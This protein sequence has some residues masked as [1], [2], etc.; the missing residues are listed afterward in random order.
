MNRSNAQ[1]PSRPDPVVM[2]IVSAI[3]AWVYASHAHYIDTPLFWLPMFALICAL[4]APVKFAQAALRWLIKRTRIAIAEVP[5]TKH[6]SARWARRK[7][8]GKLLKSKNAPF[9]GML[10]GKPLFL[11]YEA[12]AL[13]VA[14]AGA[15]KTI[16]VVIPQLLSIPQSLIA[17]DYKL[18]L[19]PMTMRARQRM[20][21]DVK[22]LDPSGITEEAFGPPDT[23][24]PLDILVDDWRSSQA[25]MLADASAMAFQLYREPPGA[26]EN[27][28]FR[29]GSR[30][31][32]VFAKVWQVIDQ[33]DRAALP[34]CLKLLRDPNALREALY[35]ASVSDALRGDLA[36]LANDALAKFESGDIRQLE[37]FREG[38]V[39]ALSVFSPSGRIASSVARSSFRY[40][41]LK[42]S[43]TSVYIGGDPTRSKVYESLMGLNAWC[44][45]TELKRC[46]SKTPVRF[47]LDEATKYYFEDLIRSMTEA[48]GFGISY[49]LIVQELEDIK[50]TYGPEALETV[51]SQTEIQQ[52]M[53]SRS[54]GTLDM[55]SQRLGNATAKTDSHAFGDDKPHRSIAETGRPLL[56]PSEI[57]EFSDS[58]VFAHGK[59][60]ARVKPVGY[61][62]VSPW[63]RPGFVGINPLHGK[64]LKGRT[65]LR[66]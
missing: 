4:A 44:A 46:R 60:P 5:S 26:S 22:R 41:D 59:P 61:H 14:P 30:N 64:R 16:C 38:A 7:D 48:R 31:L 17:F 2:A 53:T 65:R 9:W 1:S 23:Y 37:S 54:P 3:S 66:L 50:H 35:A 40:R 20:G 12:N 62:E 58:I 56:T 6:G 32:M 51:L 57:R 8:F 55:L 29:N 25:D 52:Y 28:F 24:N 15:G 27:Q 42:S 36:D 49:H 34:A 39:Q 13:T 18:E 43:R 45:N 63:N 11:D 10:E 19:F 21:H 33:G 47:L